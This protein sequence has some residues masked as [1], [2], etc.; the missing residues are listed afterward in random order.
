MKTP[1][2]MLLVPRLRS[3]ARASSRQSE[4]F[5]AVRRLV[6][7]GR[8]R[9]AG[10]ALAALL[11]AA[12]W[13][14]AG[15]PARVEEREF[16]RTPEG[17]VVRLYTLRNAHGLELR[18]M[19]YGATITELRVPDRS[20]QFT[21]VVLGSD[22]LEAYLRGH[23][24]AASV[25]G[26]YAN[27]IARA[28]FS[29]DGAEYKLAA[30]H[31]PHHLH[32]GRRNF[33]RVVWQG[34]VLPAQP[35]AAA[36]R[37]TYRSP[38]G[39]EGYPGNL[40]VSVT[41]TLTDDNEVRLDY[42]A[43][44]DRATVVNLTNHAYFNLAGHGDALGHELWLAAEQYTPA[45]E[46]L[47]PT[48]EFAPVRGTP[49]DFTRPTTIGARIEQL[50]PRPGGYDHNCV[51]RPEGRRPVLFA[52][53]VEPRSGR[54]LEALTTEP[55]VQLYTANHVRDFTGVGGAKFGHHAGFCLE[56][57]HYPDSPNQ[58]A[59]PSTVLRPGEVFTSTTVYR[60]SNRTPTPLPEAAEE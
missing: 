2:W 23:P 12:A 42:E 32:G 4:S 44:T 13:A 30:N 26:R 1:T 14:E 56:T 9:G 5:A 58:P 40:T 16:G 28:R 55:G 20:G 7:V 52:R 11:P 38:D 36:V 8:R 24:A 49:L 43:R 18:V 47:I 6:A 35:G 29:L 60:F 31:G 21:N 22:T 10:L 25:I 3:T 45:D 41:Y 15:S 54:V 19:S 27:R 48:G 46:G 34:E 39:E 51:L 53:V 37:F 59:F 57:Q 50:K 17:E 33:S